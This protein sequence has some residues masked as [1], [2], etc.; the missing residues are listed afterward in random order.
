MSVQ[1]LADTYLQSGQIDN[2]PDNHFI[3]G[4]FV[5]GSSGEKMES[6]DPARAE[7]FGSFALGSASD[8]DKAIAAAEKAAASWRKVAP[9]ERCR[10]LNNAARVLREN[11]DQLS[12][13]EV[14]DSGKTLAEAQG[15]VAGSARLFEYYAGAADKLDGR[16]VNLGTANTA[17]T[18]REPVG[19]TG[20]IIPWNYP[21]STFARGV[22]PALAAGCSVVAKPAETTPYTALVMAGLLTEAGVPEGLV[23]VV[24]GLGSE[25]GAQMAKDP[26]IK[27]LTFTGSVNTGVNVM[28]MAAP[29]VTRLTLELGGKSPLVAFEDAD[30]EAVA[31][32]AYWAIF[33]NSGQIC[34][35]GSRLVVH[36]SIRDDVIDLLVQKAKALKV[37]H[38]LKNPDMGAVNSEVHLGRIKAHVDAAKARGR[39]ILTGGNITTDPETG[40]GWFFEPTIIADLPLDDPAVQEE[41]F[42]PVLAV[43]VFDTEDDAIRL[44]NGTE[45]G[46]IGSVYT[47]DVGRAMRVSQALDCGQVSVN[48]YWAG[49]IELPFGGNGKSGYGREKG[50][51]GLDAYTKVKSI[52]ISNAS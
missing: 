43:Q 13:L 14:V 23:N 45:F 20:H 17:F 28:Q 47:R 11:A 51:E 3:D 27:Q 16:S 40:L 36:K 24:T 7:A 29:N 22:A 42:G 26:R 48:D 31:D 2:L 35:A 6:F 38:G 9:S 41:I 8:M 39:D 25:V 50:W 44:A 46:L 4:T 5:A 19:V 18:V 34:S 10:I 49:G 37:G 15:D 1:H 52:T 32:G 33:S 12:V 21:T 30:P